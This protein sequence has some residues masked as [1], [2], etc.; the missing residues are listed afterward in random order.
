MSL[1]LEADLNI[2]GEAADGLEALKLARDLKPDVVILDVEMP[3]MDGLTAAERLQT[4]APS[5][6][7]VILSLHDSLSARARAREAEAHFVAKHEGMVALVA[8]VRRAAR[9]LSPSWRPA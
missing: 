4:A 2:I 7:V 8:A 1:G 6:G 3:N 9:G 5:A